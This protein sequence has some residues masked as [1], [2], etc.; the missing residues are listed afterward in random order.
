MVQ[1]ANAVQL[2]RFQAARA[3]VFRSMRE[4][5]TRTRTAMLVPF[6]LV[7]VAALFACGAPWQ[8]LAAQLVA[9]VLVLAAL[10]VA[11]R[12]TGRRSLVAFVLAGV[13]V[14]VNVGNT[15]GVFSPLLLSVVPFL[16]GSSVH[17]N[18]ES[19]RYAHLLLFLAGFA[20]MA[21]ASSMPFESICATTPRNAHRAFL[22]LS[23]LSATLAG[24][25]V[26]KVARAMIAAYEQI[27]FE[28]A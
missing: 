22:G 1:T 8:R 10:H 3:R 28:L 11:E 23:L 13:G 21:F 4:T 26:F 5:A 16:V 15:G 17:P 27:A 9:S 25:A 6:H 18:V 19:K 7:V 24:L 14:L 20:T 2:A 12:S